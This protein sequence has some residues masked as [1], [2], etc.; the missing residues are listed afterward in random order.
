MADDD[1]GE[2][3]E[4]MSFW[5]PGGY[6]KTT[7]R[8]TDGNQLCNDLVE[9]VQERCD[10]EASYAKSLKSWSKKWATQIDKGIFVDVLSLNGLYAT[11]PNCLFAFLGPEYGSMESAWKAVLTAADRD[12]DVH[13][14]VRDNLVSTVQNEVRRWQKDNFHKSLMALHLKEKKEMDEEFKKVT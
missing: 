13:L 6:K 3:V 14:R 8:I 2:I 5:E 7:K 9:M 4:G 11:L 1:D 12:A 10:M